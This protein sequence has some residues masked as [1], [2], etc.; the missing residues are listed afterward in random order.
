MEK[1]TSFFPQL[2][3]LKIEKYKEKKNFILSL[4]VK[5]CEST[6][7]GN[8]KAFHFIDN[9]KVIYLKNQKIG[10]QRKL[11]VQVHKKNQDSIQWLSVSRSL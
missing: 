3:S 7:Y 8:I 1:S 6:I 5:E 9:T 10:T 2:L 4:K 11:F